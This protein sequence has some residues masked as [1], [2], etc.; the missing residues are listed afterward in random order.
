MDQA[1]AIHTDIDENLTK[2]ISLISLV[3]QL[4]VVKLSQMNKKLESSK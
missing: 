2:N 4:V 1:L 3:L